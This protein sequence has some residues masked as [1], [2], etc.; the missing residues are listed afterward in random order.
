MDR[1]VEIED[2]R[3]FNHSFVPDFVLKWPHDQNRT[4]DLFLRLDGSPSALAGDFE[5]LGGSHPVLFGVDGIERNSSSEEAELSTTDPDDVMVTDADA[6]E[7]LGTSLAGA[8]FGHLLP[9]SLLKGGHGWI[10]RATANALTDAA[11]RYFAGVRN[12]DAA[13]IGESI[14]VLTE[15]LDNAQ[16][17][18]IVN[19]GRI[20]WEATGG[21]P[22]GFPLPTDLEG[23]DD[24]G[25]IFLL[26]E[27]P[28][29][30]PEFWRSVGRLVT[31]ERLLSLGSRDLPNLAAFVQAN[32]D[33]IA[34]RAMAVKA[35]QPQLEPSSTR[36][37]IQNGGLAFVGGDFVAY[38]LTRRDLL[39]GGEDEASGLSTQAFERRTAHEQ[40]DTV[41]FLAADGKEVTVRSDDLFDPS[42][43]ATLSSISNLPGASIQ[44]VGLIVGGR[45]L[46]CDF[47]SRTARGATNTKFDVLSLLE[48]G[49]PMLW[50]LAV[51]EDVAAIRDLRST[52][53]QFLPPQLPFGSEDVVEPR[54]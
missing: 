31:L 48:R 13:P 11:A 17:A 25:L 47:R 41:T 53:Q 51:G 52:V 23:V 19:L 24:T 2:T 15:S 40:I 9:S 10:P 32:A 8:G 6:V 27:A 20:V 37:A 50:P 36:W 39:V 42:S 14:P 29:D 3:Y 30:D 22:V 5:F 7:D 1:T 35:S 12:H 38:L 4:R 46:E 45:H 44:S 26:Q 43:D 33:R 49:L 54:S 34:A 18:K 16:A 21:D 28:S